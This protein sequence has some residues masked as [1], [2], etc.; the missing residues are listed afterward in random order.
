[1][2]SS[3]NG[4]TKDS[5]TGGFSYPYLFSKSAVGHATS[6][7]ARELLP[8]GVRVNGIAPGWFQTGMSV[9][10]AEKDEL[11]Q[12]KN[13]TAQKPSFKIPTVATGGTNRDVGSLALFLVANWFVNGETVLIDGGTLLEHPSSY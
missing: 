1:M 4:W 11:G 9:P 5:S 2:T 6:S 13:P 10:E 8:L 7:L 3:M 12:V